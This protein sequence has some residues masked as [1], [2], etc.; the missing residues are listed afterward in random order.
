MI[1]SLEN[2]PKNLENLREK[3]NLKMRISTN[4]FYKLFSVVHS[5]FQWMFLVIDRIYDDRIPPKCPQCP[6]KLRKCAKN[7]KLKMRISTKPFYKLFSVVHNNF[8]WMCLI[9][10][11]IYDD[12]IPRKCSRICDERIC[13]DRIPPKCHQKLRK[14]H[15]KPESWKCEYLPSHFT[16]FSAWFKT[17]FYAIFQIV[18]GDCIL[19]ACSQKL[20]EKGN[21]KMRKSSKP[22]Y[23]LV[24]VV[25]NYILCI[26]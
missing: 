17:T 2:V 12:R 18:Y 25:H 15:Q 19:P 1:V 23:K 22:C 7:V 5:Y 14:L 24:S 21:L 26:F 4:P 3:V 20:A 16:N 6:Q 11:R 13:D 8:Q 10:E 9:S